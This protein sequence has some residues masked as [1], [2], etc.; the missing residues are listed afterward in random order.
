MV[1]VLSPDGEKGAHLGSHLYG[2]E[3]GLGF[4]AISRE[5][6][7]QTH[8]RTGGGEYRRTADHWDLCIERHAAA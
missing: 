8:P 3:G 2:G 1:T 5:P 4:Q 6:N 7:G